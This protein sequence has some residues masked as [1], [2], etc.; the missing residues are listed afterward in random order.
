M[1]DRRYLDPQPPFPR[2][3]VSPDAHGCTP[4]QLATD[5][6]LRS[7]FGWTPLTRSGV[8]RAIRAG[9]I[10]ATRVGRRWVIDLNALAAQ[11]D[12]RAA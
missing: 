3:H 11:A 8:I 6:A 2:V 7:R 4:E 12:S 1:L 9:T 5:P 10:P